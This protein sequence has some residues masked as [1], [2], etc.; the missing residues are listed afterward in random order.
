MTSAEH[1]HHLEEEL[2]ALLKEVAALKHS[3]RSEVAHFLDMGEY[4]LALET[5]VG[6]AMEVGVSLSAEVVLRLRSLARLME[7]EDS[8]ARRYLDDLSGGQEAS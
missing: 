6:A 1:F 3:D 5:L 7:I 4:G 2:T 8:P